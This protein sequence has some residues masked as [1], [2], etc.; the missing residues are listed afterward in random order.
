MRQ[1]GM[2][3][4]VLL[5]LLMACSGNSASDPKDTADFDGDTGFV[6]ERSP[7]TQSDSGELDGADLKSDGL[8]EDSTVTPDSLRLGV[9]TGRC[10]VPIGVPSA[11]Y[12]QAAGPEHPHSPFTEAMSATIKEQSPIQA[13]VAYLTWGDKELLLV[14]LDKIGIPM[15][16]HDEF[17]RR[18]ESR[19]GRSWEQNVILAANHSHQGPG[20]VWEDLTGEFANDSFWSFY[21][22]LY[23]DRLVDL[24]LEA[25]DD[26]QPVNVEIGRTQCPDCHSDGRCENPDI[27]DSRLWVISFSSL[28]GA[29]RAVWLN[30]PIHGTVLGWESYTLS[31]EAP[32]MIEQ[33]LEERLDSPVDV[34][35]LQSWGGDMGPGD[36]IVEAVVPAN[37]EWPEK[38][39]RLE[40]I[41]QAASD[42]V[43]QTLESEMTPVLD[44]E[45]D[46]V[47][48]RFPFH[49]DLMGYD[50]AVWPYTTGAL[51][52]GDGSDAPCYGEDGDPPNML[53]CLPMPAGAIPSDCIL[54]AFRIGT[55]A[56]LTLPGEPLTQLGLDAVAMV[57][58]E[59]DT[60]T[61][62]IVGYSQD[63][64]GYLLHEEDFWRGG[65]EPTI[66][67]WGPKQGDFLLEQVPHVL[68]KLADPSY[69]LPFELQPPR[70]TPGPA[71]KSYKT[72][73]STSKPAVMQQPDAQVH[74][75]QDV[76]ATWIGGDPWL[77]TPIVTLQHLD[78]EEWSDLLRSCG[79]PFNNNSYLMETSLAIDPSYDDTDEAQQ[80][81][82]LWTV[83]LPVS[84]NVTCPDDLKPGTYRFKFVGKVLRT[85]E[86]SYEL[87]S[88]PFEVT[89]EQ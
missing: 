77:E 38:Y 10:F 80:R 67:M 32:G 41:G 18:L 15:E 72:V 78:A 56:F 16:T 73:P 66:T 68:R 57:E 33:K 25:M 83:S 55:I 58:E 30:F 82:F 26:P 52:C 34:F 53:G 39:N 8:D 65:Y 14:R 45:L 76:N 29:L 7:D 50:T 23:M 88:Q 31:T 40:R 87:F 12:S 49:S 74:P 47:T 3:Y 75:G 81:E 13:K 37:P 70:K 59:L 36:P 62:L 89:F 43:L 1:K 60:D 63:H 2:A 54:S 44:T 21:Y 86:G 4:W 69:E 9:A 20:R 61:A 17:V 28:D 6:D 71:G 19:T 51:L 64:W 27:K 84:R 24:A 35:L 11:G 48:V 46:S 42:V 5:M 22:N 85:S 79:R